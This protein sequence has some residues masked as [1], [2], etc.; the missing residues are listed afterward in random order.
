M[1]VLLAVVLIFASLSCVALEEG[2]TYR[3]TVSTK[4]YEKYDDFKVQKNGI[5][6]GHNSKFI[7]TKVFEGGYRISFVN[8]YQLP[9]FKSYEGKCAKD[10][11]E[12]E[13]VLGGGQIS[14]GEGWANTKALEHKEYLIPAF[15]LIDKEPN[16]SSLD[17]LTRVSLSGPVTGT[18]IIPFKYRLNDKSLEGESTIGLYAGWAVDP[19]WNGRAAGVVFVPFFSLGLTNVS[20]SETDSTGQ[21]QSKSE[22]GVTIACGILLNNWSNTALGLVL[23]QDRIGDSS[24]EHEGKSWVSFSVGWKF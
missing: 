24:W 6:V 16:K 21:E 5:E 20:V 10:L 14:H 17:K 9:C 4:V 18:L 23:G 2:E 15:V 19:T 7:V 12:L 13:T 3:L 22:S 8:I 11:A 1:K